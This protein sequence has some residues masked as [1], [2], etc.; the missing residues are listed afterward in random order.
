MTNTKST[1]Q[2]AEFRDKIFAEFTENLTDYFTA[3]TS[4]R[5]EIYRSFLY[6]DNHRV[7]VHDT[8]SRSTTLS[9]SSLAS[10]LKEQKKRDTNISLLPAIIRGVAGSE[11]MQERQIDIVP[12]VDGDTYDID[13]DIMDDCVTYAQ[14]ASE[15]KSRWDMA[16]RDA[17][18]CGIGATVTHLD[19]TKK[20][21]ASGIPRVD[22][23]HPSFLFY[24]TSGRGQELNATAQWCGYADPMKHKDLVDYIN[25]NQEDGLKDVSTSTNDALGDSGFAAQFMQGKTN[26]DL[27]LDMLYHYFWKEDETVY[28]TENLVNTDEIFAQ[29]MQDDDIALELM[30]RWAHSAKVDIAA[31]YWTLEQDAFN[32]LKKTVKAIEALSEQEFEIKKSKRDVKCFYRAEIGLGRV[33]KFSKAFSQKEFPINFVTGYFDEALGV[34]YGFTRPISFVQDALNIVMDDLMEYSHGAANGGKAWIKGSGDDIKL[35]KQS[36]SNEDDVTPIPSDAEIIPKELAATPQVLLSTAQL[37]IEL[38]P[39]TIGVGQEFLG[40]ISSGTMTDSLFGRI[41]KQSFAVLAD[42]ANNSASYSRRQGYIFVDLMMSI[43]EAEDGRILPVL[44][45]GHSEENYFKM[46]LQNMARDYSI[47]VMERPVTDDER[48]ENMK[49]LTQVQPQLAQSGVNI[50]PAIVENMRMDYQPK[51]EL[52]EMMTPKQPAPDPKA[53]ESL[54]VNLDLLR[55]QTA[56]LNADAAEVESTLPMQPRL[57]ETEI[58]KNTSIAMKNVAQADEV[59]EQSAMT[60]LNNLIQARA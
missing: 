24:D 48:M 41:V 59:S 57:T 21:Y 55:A 36:K 12:M 34:Y 43:A 45:P 25:R 33:I 10:G 50:M 2:K 32:D 39:R 3:T 11:V 38:M 49:V 23:K 17:A 29:V 18:V 16:K 15:W 40:I 9:S 20:D 28:D 30:S 58:D 19:M 22:R 42:F 1:T 14:Y 26:T 60:L 54:Q 5:D 7:D 27:L 52:L 35:I 6:M 4:Q 46:T 53:E 56:K 31:P 37:L 8:L 13:A 51:K 44:S 47:R